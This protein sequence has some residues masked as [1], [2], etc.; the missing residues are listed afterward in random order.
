MASSVLVSQPLLQ[1][2][3]QIYKYFH[4]DAWK[5][6]EKK[7]QYSPLSFFQ[8]T[9][10]SSHTTIIAAETRFIEIQA[11]LFDAYFFHW[12]LRYFVVPLLGASHVLGADWGE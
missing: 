9:K 6:E 3:T 1:E 10:T 5:A 8:P 11:P 4:S 12:F 7:M 2:K